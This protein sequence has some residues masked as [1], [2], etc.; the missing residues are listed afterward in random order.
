MG[1]SA[2]LFG[3]AARP[4][5]DGFPG[6][7]ND[8]GFA[9]ALI[10]LGAKLAKA[11]G[12]VSRDEI[13]AFKRV[14][15]AP[16]EAEAGM[17]RFFDLARQ[18]TLGYE[19]YAKII[20]RKFR[21]K[22]AALEDVL[23][24]LFHI[25]LADGIVSPDEMVFLETVADIFG[26]SEREFRRI[27]TAHLGRSADDPYLILGIDE[28]ISDVDLKKAYRRMAAANHPDRLIA[29]GLPEQMQRLANHKMAMINEAYAEILRQRKNDTLHKLT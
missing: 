4:D 5:M 20:A 3:P 7:V 23:D 9:A 1:A 16:P 29:R 6:R 8:A 22:P 18:T 28:D 11:D 27:R 12:V 17:A 10:G 15:Q 13:E 25:A 14:F 24:G 19:T 2:R 26:F 21:A